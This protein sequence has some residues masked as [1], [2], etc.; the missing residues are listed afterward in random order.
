MFRSALSLRFVLAVGLFACGWQ[1]GCAQHRIPAIDPTGEHIFSGTTT[2][3]SHD[4]FNGGLFHKHH[5]PAAAGVV[6]PAAVA[7]DPQIK[8][9]CAPPIEAVP[10]VPLVPVPIVAVP[11]NPLPVAI[12][13]PPVACEPPA[14]RGPELT[15]TP[16]RIVAPVN[17]EVVM[18]TRAV[19]LIAPVFAR[20][21]D[22]PV[23]VPL[24]V[25]PFAF[26]ID[27]RDSQAFLAVF[28]IQKLFPVQDA[29]AIGSFGR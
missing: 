13:G 28:V 22:L 26:A 19:Q 24:G 5:Q 25:W 20:G 6:A 10:V 3:A 16:S 18:T 15:V 2:L 8:P 29:M 1:S 9:P 7:V 12:A 21:A 27:D 23:G 14:Y 17:T 4:L 11:Q